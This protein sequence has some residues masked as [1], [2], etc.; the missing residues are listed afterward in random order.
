MFNYW[1][2]LRWEL[3]GYDVAKIKSEKKRR[4]LKKKKI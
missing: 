3:Y 4:K 1:K 2:E